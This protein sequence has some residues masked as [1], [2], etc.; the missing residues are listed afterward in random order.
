LFILKLEC[1]N[2][3]LSN[4]HD[5]NQQNQQINKRADQLGGRICL[6]V[7]SVEK[8]ICQQRRGLVAPKN[9]RGGTD[10]L[11]TFGVELFFKDP[12]GE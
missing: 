11:K 2:Q 1:R 6:S 5:E 10:T 12:D 3:V 9:P 7:T 4:R 8:E